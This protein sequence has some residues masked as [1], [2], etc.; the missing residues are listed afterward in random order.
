MNEQNNQMQQIRDLS[1]VL[2]LTDHIKSVVKNAP[3][4]IKINGEVYKK[5]IFES[6]NLL[7]VS[8]WRKAKDCQDQA[9]HRYSFYFGS[10]VHGPLLPL[11]VTAIVAAVDQIADLYSLIR[12]DEGLTFWEKLTK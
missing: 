11:N 8:Y 10:T 4:K 5:K 1:L 12:K 7:D 9:F 6:E 3:S 2:Q